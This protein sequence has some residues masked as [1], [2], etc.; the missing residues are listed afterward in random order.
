M[1]QTYRTYLQFSNTCNQIADAGLLFVF[2]SSISLVLQQ[3]VIEFVRLLCLV[4]I[5]FRDL[6]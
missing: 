2:Q 1:N 3:I 6:F 5:V 4:V